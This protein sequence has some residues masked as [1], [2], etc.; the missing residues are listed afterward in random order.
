M[1][2]LDLVGQAFKNIGRQKLRSILTI[3]AV[4]I[5]ATSVTIMLA[6][7]SGAQTFFVSQFSANGTLQQIA[8]SSQTDLVEVLQT[9]ITAATT[10][11]PA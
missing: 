10:V 8:I 9:A 2:P 7:V 6:L 1:K 3:F 5:G 4:T 11:T